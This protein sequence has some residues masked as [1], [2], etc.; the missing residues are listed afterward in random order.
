MNNSAYVIRI[1]SQLIDEIAK[2]GKVKSFGGMHVSMPG[3][4]TGYEFSVTIEYAR[5]GD[6]EL[7]LTST[8]KRIKQ[9]QLPHA[10]RTS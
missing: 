2:G 5:P 6:K 7:E 3:K 4:R 8:N 10:K 9:G 1:M